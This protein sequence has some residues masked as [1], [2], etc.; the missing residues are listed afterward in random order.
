[1]GFFK[2]V[3]TAIVNFEG[4]QN[5]ANENI[6]KAIKYFFQIVFIFA[7]LATFSAI[8]PLIDDLRET[9]EYVRS[10]VPNFEVKDD[11]LVL[12]NEEI[13]DITQEEASLKILANPKLSQD[14]INAFFEENKSFENIMVFAEN[15]FFVKLQSTSGVIA[16]D[17]KTITQTIEVSELSKQAILDYFDNSGYVKVFGAVFLFILAYLFFTYIIVT[18]LDILILSLLATI[19]AKLYKT[20]LVYKQCFSMA[21]Y[22]LTLPIILH[23][24][25]LLINAFTGF[26][27]EYFQIMY[28]IISYIYVVAAILLIKAD[29]NKTGSDVV[30]IIAE[31]EKSSEEKVEEKPTEEKPEEK[32][33]ENKKEEKDK[34]E[35]EPTPG[36]A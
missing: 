7:V 14:E 25:Y 8:Y 21:I 35:P 16:Y 36:K 5:F 26:T 31:I 11:K 3:K 30:K 17:Y 4:Y 20:N 9:V 32:N 27:I 22:A 29:F 33:E 34:G 15:Q 6:G 23:A 13:V 24:I 19:T 2:R 10:N 28:N 1:M 12:E 18:L